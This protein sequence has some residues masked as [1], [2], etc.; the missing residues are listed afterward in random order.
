MQ[1]DI[2]CRYSWFLVDCAAEQRVGCGGFCVSVDCV[3]FEPAGFVWVGRDVF[4]RTRLL[5]PEQKRQN[6]GRDNNCT[7]AI[8]KMGHFSGKNIA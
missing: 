4:E 8:S 5:T 3:G 1:F 2:G 6:R 7:S